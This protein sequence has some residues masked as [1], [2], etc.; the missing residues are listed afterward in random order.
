MKDDYTRFKDELL[1]RL[2]AVYEAGNVDSVDAFALADEMQTDRR[3][4][5]DVMDGLK[6]AGDVRS[7]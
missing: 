3:I 5:K 2:A 7:V 4:A 1:L 6:E